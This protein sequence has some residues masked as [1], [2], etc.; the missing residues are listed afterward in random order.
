MF[1]SA[2]EVTDLKLLDGREMG[3]KNPEGQKAIEPT[4]K[5]WS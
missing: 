3:G 2:C 4:E 1:L 5:L